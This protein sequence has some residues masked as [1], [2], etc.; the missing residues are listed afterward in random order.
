M[1]NREWLRSLSNKELTKLICNHGSCFFCS[2]RANKC[3]D[4]TLFQDCENGICE[5]LN[6]EHGNPMPE[7]KAGDFI[8]TKTKEYGCLI[9]VCVKE[10]EG[11]ILSSIDKEK[12]VSLSA[13]MY[14]E[15]RKICR[16]DNKKH[17]M[18]EIWSADDD[19]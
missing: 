19:R 12:C 7:M 15:I 18:T 10:E 6:S 14:K 13:F 8:Y 5:W 1:T 2:Y 9:L 17:C 3:M 11:K 16:Y 4:D